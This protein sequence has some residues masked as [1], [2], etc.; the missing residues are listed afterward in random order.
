MTE[1]DTRHIPD[2]STSTSLASHENCDLRALRYGHLFSYTI[3]CT[4][5]SGDIRG[6]CT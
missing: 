2:W 3:M 4:F 5:Q 6:V 1:T